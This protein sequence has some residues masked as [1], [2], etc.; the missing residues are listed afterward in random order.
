MPVFHPKA[1]AYIAA[2]PSPQNHICRA[3]RHL[4]LDNFPQMREEYKWNYP[5]YYFAGRRI[6]LFGGFKH[7]VSLELF[8]E[9]HLRD[10]QGRINGAG[11]RTRHIKFLTLKDVDAA[12]LIE[13]I[14]QSLTLSQAFSNA[15]R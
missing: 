15:K 8:Y 2:Q 12:Y 6:C 13:L 11:K 10:S 14:E 9:A 4:I 7:H 1:T 5:A 3:L